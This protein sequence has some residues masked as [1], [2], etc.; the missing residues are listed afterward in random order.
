MDKNTFKSETPKI[1]VGCGS[2]YPTLLLNSEGKPVKVLASLGKGGGC[3]L[4]HLST[5]CELVSHIISHE[6]ISNITLA[7]TSAAGHSCQYGKNNCCVNRLMEYVLSEVLKHG[8][9]KQEEN[10]E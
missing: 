3:A 4:A 2:L 1:G 7:L 10:D 8:D 5:H 6:S 9:K